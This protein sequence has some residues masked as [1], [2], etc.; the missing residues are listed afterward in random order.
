MILKVATP[1]AWV[2]AAVLQWQD[3][4]RT[5]ESLLG[6]EVTGETPARPG[7][8]RT[9]IESWYPIRED[10]AIVGII[11]V[12][13]EIT[14]RK[15][16]EEGLRESESR[17]RLAVDAAS[18]ISFEWDIPRNEVRRRCDVDGRFRDVLLVDFECSRNVEIGRAHV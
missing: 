11:G 15:R 3:L 10:G 8:R 18:L 17:L 9:W 14:D 4:L 6:V 1:D 2:D 5:G 13:E 7:V 16:V 12:V